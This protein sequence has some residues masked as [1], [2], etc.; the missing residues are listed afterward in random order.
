[1]A[2]GLGADS[3]L[4]EAAQSLECIIKCNECQRAEAH[5][6][7]QVPIIE[8]GPVWSSTEEELL[9]PN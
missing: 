7:H 5:L 1:M 9:W 2:L 6:T 4:E 3:R 8:V